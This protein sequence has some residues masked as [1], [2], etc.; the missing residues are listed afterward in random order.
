MNNFA[1][2]A[3]VQIVPSRYGF[4]GGGCARMLARN[5]ILGHLGVPLLGFWEASVFHSGCTTSLSHKDT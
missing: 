1:V 2:N 4:Q 5:A 3:R